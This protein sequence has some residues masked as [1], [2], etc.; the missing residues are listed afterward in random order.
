MLGRDM[1]K[2]L[3]ALCKSQKSGAEPQVD[4]LIGYSR[5]GHLGERFGFDVFEPEVPD[6]N[7]HSHAISRS[8]VEGGESKYPSVFV[9][10]PRERLLSFCQ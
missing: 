9:V 2:G 7:S 3:S 4:Y 8:S 5:L 10:M 1:K 6:F